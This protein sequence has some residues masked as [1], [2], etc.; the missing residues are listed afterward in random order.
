MIEV[1]Y[2]E[3]NQEAQNG[4][5]TFG[6]PKNI[7]QI[8]LIRED[9]KIYM[10]DYVYT[11]LVR[12]ARA[13]EGGKPKTRVAVLTGETK[14]QGGTTYLFVKGAVMA[15]DMEAALDHIDFSTEIWKKINEEQKK[16]F[17]DQE[18]VGW[19]FS[20]PQ[21]SI[22]INEVLAKVHLKHFGGEKVLMLMEPQEREDAFFRYE[23][24]TM[25][26]LGGYY[27]YY[28]KNPC[29]QSYMLDKNKVLQPDVGEQYE[30]KA[31][32]DFRK[33]ITDKNGEKKEREA[34][35]VFSYGVTA[36]LAVAVLAVG[37]NFFR[38][39]QGFQQQKGDSMTVSSVIVEEVS[40]SPQG[41]QE[42]SA[43]NVQ[44]SKNNS[45]GNN[46]GSNIS[47]NSNSGASGNTDSQNT[48]T[49]SLNAENS[50]TEN[51]NTGNPDS[52]N[53]DAGKNEK[54]T[55]GY[56]V[57]G[58]SKDQKGDSQQTSENS[59]TDTKQST[60]KAVRESSDKT[61]QVPDTQNNSTADTAAADGDTDAAAQIYQ[62][63][64]DDRKAQKRVREAAQKENAEAASRA[65]HESY[66]IQPG[67]T[68]FQISMDRYG[69]IDAIAQICALNGITA[70]QIIYPGEIIVLP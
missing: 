2:K 44:N 40:P 38:N 66:V 9:Y 45:S 65:A 12:L 49:E 60:D 3:E 11:F 25:T 48:N 24:N 34:P 56:S 13:E 21:L 57:S 4:E 15:G 46:T 41:Q 14:W 69:S 1:I 47:G 62:E 5:G 36:C 22:E 10:E 28:E 26:R 35:S 19:F 53:A 16:Y 8:G 39:Y 70:D 37:V 31:V 68:L 54:E 67:D 33:I 32:K 18:I 27:L 6:L 20:Q 29:M 30:D 52:D 51:L 50:D 61:E 43:R 7:R 63:E 64:S 23:N 58:E 42:N 17:E 55:A 59:Q